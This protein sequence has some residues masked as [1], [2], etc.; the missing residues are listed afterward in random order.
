MKVF[1]AVPVLLAGICAHAQTAGYEFKR[2][3]V[4]TLQE[5][6]PARDCV[7]VVFIGDGYVADDLV[8]DGAYEKDVRRVTEELFATEP[9]RSLQSVFNVRAV[10]ACSFARGADDR[11][12][13]DSRATILD[14]AFDAP[15]GRNV[16]YRR[17]ENVM[18]LARLAPAADIV[19]V[20]INDPRYGGSGGVIWEKT[21]APCFTNAQRSLQIAVHEL[22]HSLANL[23]DEYTDPKEAERR[24]LP[25]GTQ[26]LPYPNLTR[27]KHV[28]LSSK[29][30]LEA[31]VKWKHLLDLPG[32]EGRIGAFEG[33]YYRDSGVFRPEEKCKMR[34]SGDPFC[35]VCREEITRSIYA[36]IGRKF[37]HAAYHAANP[38]TPEARR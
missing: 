20:M 14:C 28:D 31:T 18:R 21:P 11:P 5:S 3:R 26:D 7:D 6:G 30:T 4:E 8:A 37:D 25:D 22:G 29:R 23:G 19:L 15:D 17:D 38:L 12:V 32:A 9:F 1:L 24:P 35:A 27:A 10:Y 36:L 16:T 13:E 34:A 33:G 2:V